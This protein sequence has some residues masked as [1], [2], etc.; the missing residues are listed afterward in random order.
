MVNRSERIGAC[1]NRRI[2]EDDIV[3]RVASGLVEAGRKE[4][5]NKAHLCTHNLDRSVVDPAL[6]PE[7]SVVLAE[8][9]LIEVEPDIVLSTACDA[10]RVNG[11]DGALEEPYPSGDLGARSWFGEQPQGLREQ[12]VTRL[13]CLGRPKS[14]EDAGDRSGRIEAS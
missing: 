2:E 14:G 11:A 4:V 7:P 6:F 5:A 12:T 3:L 9:Q 10:G 1:A 13:Q 8:E